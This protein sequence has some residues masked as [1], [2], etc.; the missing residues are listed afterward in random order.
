MCSSFSDVNCTSCAQPRSTHRLHLRTMSRQPLYSSC[1]RLSQ[2][3]PAWLSD[4]FPVAESP[5]ISFYHSYL[6]CLPLPLCFC[7]SL[8]LYSLSL[9]SSQLFPLSALP[10]F[11]LDSA[12]GLACVLLCLLDLCLSAQRAENQRKRNREHSHTKNNNNNNNKLL[13]DRY[14]NTVYC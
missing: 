13:A 9:S 7:P 3:Q 5:T 12:S 11:C 4:F 2:H 14:S 10:L 1:L 8:T 6:H